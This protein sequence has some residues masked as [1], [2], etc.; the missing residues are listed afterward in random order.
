MKVV[1]NDELQYL[2]TLQKMIE[3]NNNNDDYDD[4]EGDGDGNEDDDEV[5]LR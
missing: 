1:N 3:N 4:G 2:C 5:L